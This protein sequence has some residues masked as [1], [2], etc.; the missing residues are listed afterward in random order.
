MTCVFWKESA[1]ESYWGAWSP[2]GCNTEQPSPSQVLCRCDHL[3][4]FAVLMVC[5]RLV[6]MR[7]VR[8]AEGPIPRTEQKG[9]SWC[10]GQKSTQ[11]DLR[12]GKKKETY[13]FMFL[14]GWIGLQAWLDPGTQYY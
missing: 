13:E 7:V 8:A 6:W 1:N 3:T 2:E 10:K 11:R 4:Y 12:G 5:M 14:K 9:K